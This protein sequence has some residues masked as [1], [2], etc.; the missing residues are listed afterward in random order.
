MFP[1]RQQR[2]EA[3][4]DVNGR[5]GS[6]SGGGDVEPSEHDPTMKR[7][8]GSITV[9]RTMIGPASA[10]LSVEEGRESRGERGG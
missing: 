2:I 8:R 10:A 3:N 7:G 1:T 5:A 9:S 4:D 6:P